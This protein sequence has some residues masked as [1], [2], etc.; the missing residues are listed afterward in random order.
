MDFAVPPYL[1]LP[2]QRLIFNRHSLGDDALGLLTVPF[3]RRLPVLRLSGRG[4]QVHSLAALAPGSHL[5]PALCGRHSELLVLLAALCSVVHRSLE[6]APKRVKLV[7]E[8][9]EL[10]EARNVTATSL[11]KREAMLQ[12]VLSEAD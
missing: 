8:G 2:H 5:A 11:P 6:E 12:P 3:R 4:S 1:G 9:M 7:S 10:R